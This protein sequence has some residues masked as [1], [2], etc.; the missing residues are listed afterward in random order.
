MKIDFCIPIKNES[1]V[2]EENLMKLKKYLEGL[3][4][5]SNWQIIGANNGSSDNSLDILK[6]LHSKFPECFAYLNILQ[7]GKGR[8]VKA[9]WHQSEADILVFMDADLAVDLSGIEALI[10]PLLKNEADLVIGS[11]FMPGAITQRSWQRGLISKSYALFSKIML[12]HDKGDLQCG[13]KAITQSAFRK[14]EEYLE[15]DSWFLDTEIVV[16]SNLIGHR[17]LEI[18]VIWKEKRSG[19][20]KS[21]VNVFKDGWS[22][23]LKTIAFKKRLKRLKN[24]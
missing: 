19:K 6:N 1:L 14:I 3:D 2:L 11:R 17:I 15:D 21:N 4:L 20:N 13:F 18:P 9:C 16:I 23:L 22:F 8:A 5:M 10:S 7:P 24:I 12:G